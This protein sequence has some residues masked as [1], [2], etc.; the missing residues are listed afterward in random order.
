VIGSDQSETWRPS[1]SGETVGGRV[2]D[3]RI[4]ISA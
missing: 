3:E 2:E 1:G 4:T